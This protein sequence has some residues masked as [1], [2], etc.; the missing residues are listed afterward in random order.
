MLVDLKDREIKLTKPASLESIM[1]EEGQKFDI[2]SDSFKGGNAGKDIISVIGDDE[3]L[4]L[5]CQDEEF[6]LKR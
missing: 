2:V 3:E 4:V 5:K 6:V 1:L